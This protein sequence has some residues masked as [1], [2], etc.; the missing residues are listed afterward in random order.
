MSS[1]T[2]VSV[3]RRRP[4]G[5]VRPRPT[6]IVVAHE[7][8]MIAVAALAYI[9]I[10]AVTEGRT[11][12]AV[13]N[14]LELIRLQQALGVA[15]ETWFQSLIIGSDALVAL[16]N[17]VYIYGHWPVI[18]T[19]AV[20]LFLARRDRYRLLR[21]AVF[22]SGAIGFL[23]F[24][25]VPLAPPRLLSLGLVDTVAEQSAAYRALQPPALAN[26]FA[27]M[28][29]LHFGWNL[30]VGIV[31]FG[32]T[33][34]LLV[35]AFAVLLPAAMAVAVVATAN[36]FV[37]DVVVGAVVVLVGLALAVRIPRVATLDGN[38][39]LQPGGDPVSDRAPRR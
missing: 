34:R 27:A 39:A 10:R 32:T 1:A 23:F 13:H 30:L 11:E 15:W 3:A 2:G 16:A 38:G 25:F 12:V 31:V 19:V 5:P 28:P 29:S 20:V 7:T 4:P 17:W 37:L 24:A 8:A 9:G 22:I 6:A 33:R 35:R 14:A 18:A 26:Q 36:H 21:N